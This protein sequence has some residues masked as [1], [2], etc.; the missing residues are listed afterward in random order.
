MFQDVERE[1]NVLEIP[2]TNGHS[3]PLSFQIRDQLLQARLR[4]LYQHSCG[5]NGSDLGHGLKLLL[6]REGIDVLKDVG[7]G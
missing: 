4:L 3:D 5:F 7:F 1:S 6:R 2:G